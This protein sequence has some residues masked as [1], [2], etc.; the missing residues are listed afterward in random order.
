M[1]IK[2]AEKTHIATYEGQ[3]SMGTQM[4]SS[5]IKLQPPV[6]SMEKEG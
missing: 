2:C 4:C 3:V 5:K 1:M 6:N